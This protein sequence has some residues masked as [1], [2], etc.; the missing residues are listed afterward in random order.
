MISLP[1]ANSAGHNYLA[2][3][4]GKAGPAPLSCL[5]G[6]I[7]INGI[8]LALL[9]G[10][11]RQCLVTYLKHFCHY[12]NST[13][14]PFSGYGWNVFSFGIDVTLYSLQSHCFPFSRKS[15]WEED[16]NPMGCTLMTMLTAMHQALARSAPMA[17]GTE[18]FLTTCGRPKM[19]PRSSTTVPAPIGLK[20]KRGS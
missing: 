15:P 13:S 12:N 3:M 5:N 4:L 8:C 14:L 11:S 1:V 6:L 16:M 9:W 7:E 18:A 19:W 20:G 2:F 17:P 10:V